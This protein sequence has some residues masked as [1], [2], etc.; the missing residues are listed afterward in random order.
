MDENVRKTL[1][2]R[3]ASG[4]I[5]I[6]E[7]RATL[8]V[9]RN[10]ATEATESTTA[11]NLRSD[12]QTEPRLILTMD[13][14]LSLFESFLV[15]KGRRHSYSTITSL[16]YSRSMTSYNFIPTSN[17]TNFNIELENGETIT[18][19]TKTVFARG[20]LSK[21]LEQ[22]YLFLQP[23]TFQ[24]RLNRTAYQLAQKGS[25]LVPSYPLGVT[26]FPNGDIENDKGTRLN[27]KDS[28]KN[29]ALLIGVTYTNLV[30]SPR[31]SAPDE[32][33]IYENQKRFGNK[34]IIF[35]LLVDQDV[36]KALISWL[37]EPGNVLR[38]IT[39]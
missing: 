1:D 31:G 11:R 30:G 21:L 29:N 39:A 6:E 12:G 26:L 2:L 10:S 15:Y 20:N 4:E 34:K 35:T 19:S 14:D 7:Y 9:L 13:S 23:A 33:R 28:K 32:I 25:I 24:S 36:W 27:L 5:T 38:S 17:K 22:A 16:A 8:N 18:Y 3:L 37:A